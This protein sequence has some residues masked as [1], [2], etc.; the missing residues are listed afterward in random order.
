MP[1]HDEE[2]VETD[3]AEGIEFTQSKD[4]DVFGSFEVRGTPPPTKRY[5]AR[6]T[7][8]TA[9]RFDSRRVAAVVFQPLL[10]AHTAGTVVVADQI[11]H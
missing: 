2:V 4:V 5:D 3:D 11:T 8:T 7:T 9:R 6:A 10:G 1:R